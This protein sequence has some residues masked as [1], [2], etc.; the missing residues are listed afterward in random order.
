MNAPAD[1][2]LRVFITGGA[3][4]VGAVLVPKLLVEGYSIT[5]YDLLLYG[6]E[7]VN[8]EGLIIPHPR[9]HQRAFVPQPL[10][11]VAGDANHPILG[12]RIR[13]LLGEVSDQSGVRAWE[14][15]SGVFPAHRKG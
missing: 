4:Y 6:D 7:I 2:L 14:G 5:V 13:E 9:L 15:R 10:A 3:G 11:D 8:D 1:N 12:K